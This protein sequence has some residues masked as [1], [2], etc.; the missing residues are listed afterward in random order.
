MAS[1]D[2]TLSSSPESVD[3]RTRDRLQDAISSCSVCQAGRVKHVGVCWASWTRAFEHA[4]LGEVREVRSWVSSVWSMRRGFEEPFKR[5]ILGLEMGVWLL[6]SFHYLSPSFYYL[7]L[8]E[9]Q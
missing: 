4:G 9:W 3:S 1:S 5:G 2:G 7:L 6:T 8:T